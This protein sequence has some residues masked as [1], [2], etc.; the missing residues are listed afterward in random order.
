MHFVITT[1]RTDWCT[2][3]NESCQIM[4][5]EI[6]HIYCLDV[7]RDKTICARC[8]I[9]VKKLWTRKLEETDAADGRPERKKRW[10]AQLDSSWMV[11]EKVQWRKCE[12][13]ERAWWPECNSKACSRHGLEKRTAWAIKQLPWNEVISLIHA[14]LEICNVEVRKGKKMYKKVVTRH[15][16][17]LPTAYSGC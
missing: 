16:N 6:S 11:K 2:N 1:K 4:P 17:P 14:E 5:D 3:S 12:R 15:Y 7:W 13:E 9:S 8:L 10:R